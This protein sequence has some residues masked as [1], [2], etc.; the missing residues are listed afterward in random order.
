[1]KTQSGISESRLQERVIIEPV[2]AGRV[3]GALSAVDAAPG[4]AV[5]LH[6]EAF[7][8]MCTQKFYH[9][10]E[11]DRNGR[12]SLSF[13]LDRRFSEPN[14][15]ALCAEVNSRISQSCGERYSAEVRNCGDGTHSIVIGR[16]LVIDNFY[17][18]EFAAEFHFKSNG[19]VDYRFSPEHTRVASPTVFGHEATT[20]LT[21]LKSFVEASY[22]LADELPP[23]QKLSLTV[24]A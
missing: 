15:E 4:Q 11:I 1:M 21:I 10:Q 24:D 3:F 6:G 5:N 12:L 2:D 9:R 7:G 17:F 16:G 14:I 23:P 20:A 13:P 22:R 18:D 19:F 8:S